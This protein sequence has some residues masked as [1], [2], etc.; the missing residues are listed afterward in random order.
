MKC[1]NLQSLLMRTILLL[2]TCVS[3]LLTPLNSWAKNYSLNGNTNSANY[4]DCSGSWSSNSGTITCSGKITLSLGDTIIP[5]QSRVLVAN[6]GFDLPGNNILG[7][8]SNPMPIQSS[9]GSI[10]VQGDNNAIY[11]AIT[12]N[13]GTINLNN[14]EV[15]GDIFLPSGSISI[16]GGT[17]LGNTHSNCC[18]VTMTNTQITGDVSSSSSTVRINGGVINGNL[19]TN[20]GSGV[21]VENATMESGAITTA[22][23]PITLSNSQIGSTASPINLQSANQINISSDTTVYGNVTAG[24]WSSS[25]AIDMTSWVNGLCSPSHPR[26]GAIS[27]LIASENFDS[28]SPGSLQGGSAGEGWTGAWRA[29]S[30]SQSVIDTS[31]NPLVYHQGGQCIAGASRALQL[32]GTTDYAASR[33]LSRTVDDDVVYVS[34]LVRFTGTQAVNKFFALWFQDPTYQNH[35]NIGI[36]MNRGT[37][38]GPE[39]FFV[40]TTNQNETYHT[41]LV[42]GQTYFLV[43]RLSKSSPGSSNRYDRFELW[44]DPDNLDAPGS[45]DVVTDLRNSNIS[46]F[47]EIGFRTYHLSSTDELLVDSLT[48]G[49]DWDEVVTPSSDCPDLVLTCMTDEFAREVLGND[50]SV[51]HQSGGFGNP[52][53]VQQRLRMTDASGNVATA[54]TLQRLFPSANNLITVEFDFYAYGG[55]GADGIAVVLSDAAITPAPGGYGGSLGYAQRSGGINGFAGGWLGIGLDSYGNFSNPSESRQGG[56][57]RRQ[58]S[59][60][61]RGSGAANSG[62]HYIQ[63]TDTLSPTVRNTSGHRY[64]ITVDSRTGDESW[65]TIERDTGAGYENLIGP[66]D[67]LSSAGQAQ[68]PE[69]LLLT[70]TGST[71]GSNDNHEIDN[72]EVCGLRMEPLEADIHHYRL[73]HSGSGLTCAAEPIQVIAC[74]SDNCS[75]RFTGTASV[76]LS[77]ASSG[78]VRWIDGNQQYLENGEATFQLRRNTPGNVTLGIAASAPSA[79]NVTRCFSNG[80]EGD[81]TL[82]F[83]ESG[84][85]FDLPDLL[86]DKPDSFT[87]SARR[88]DENNPDSCAPAFTGER[89]IN[90]RSSYI[91]PDSGNQSVSLN[92]QAISNTAGWTSLLLAFDEHANAQVDIRYPDAGLKQLEAAFTGTAGSDE[93]GLSLSGS[94]SFSSAPAGLCIESTAN[95]AACD[96]EDA[97]CSV[98]TQAGEDFPMRVRGVVWTADNDPQLCDNTTTPNY[99]QSN[100]TLSSSL[101]APSDGRNA[102]LSLSQVNITENGLQTEA[103]NLSEVGVFQLL[104]VPQAN[105][106]FGR[107]VTA[108]LSTPIGRF[109]PSHFSMHYQLDAACSTGSS[110]AFSYSGYQSAASVQNSG[111]PFQ[112]TGHILALNRQE[113]PTYNYRQAFAKLTSADLTGTAL[114]APDGIAEGI[115]NSWSP[116]LETFTQGRGDFSIN[117]DYLAQQR[118]HSPLL[119]YPN[120]AATDSDDVS[121]SE[122]DP[123]AAG[124][125]ISG[126]MVIES[127]HAFLET[128]PINL[129]LDAQMYDG[130][131]W[132]THS[133][134]RCT[135]VS[136]FRMDNDQEEN[137]SSNIQIGAGAT[138][139]LPNPYDAF[140]AGQHSLTLSAPGEG[141]SG[142]TNL[143]PLLN[144]Q[145][146]LRHDWTGNGQYTDNPSGRAAWGLYRG[147]PN[148]IY[149]REVWR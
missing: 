69:N 52:R 100:I 108:G 104:A 11:G 40:R 117:T 86:A 119:I 125:F 91:N 111:Q 147:N 36:K 71:G 25:L 64:R 3:L 122:S 5:N 132:T 99:R 57:G 130:S 115:F 131:R 35:P 44:V 49:L 27:S 17:V 129:T 67:I 4:P 38:S 124:R 22:S 41:D 94:D 46:A 106:Y 97:N 12:S 30:N 102:E 127:G 15:E 134:D 73:L 126:R 145:P 87:L 29:H 72:L 113:Q 136:A 48:L 112:I 76:T 14:A 79:S 68:V 43:G 34:M 143:T 105:S 96:S 62:Y 47:D 139:L 24:G 32:R 23:V 19:S 59:V 50:W 103:I 135:S 56:P 140:D 90:F 121:G 75:S 31:Q 146:W 93:Q 128:D 37:G 60:A 20:G 28:Y 7:S 95:N 54:A 118:P 77:P 53:I 13:S 16:S 33:N 58:N 144:D 55:N 1:L 42:S 70:L 74:A 63:G 83:A 133:A 82:S 84:F 26:C 21:I 89:S 66:V 81:C 45:P 98:F 109:I 142:F 85:I 148:V 65:V 137:Q 123:A 61:L 116:T 6:A 18:T 8:S 78:T 9:W 10:S 2:L 138:S 107:T 80:I 141:N 101:I 120:L 88:A 149:M 92:G 51:T 114:L 39:D 110:D